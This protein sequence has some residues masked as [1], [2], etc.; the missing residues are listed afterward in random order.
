[1]CLNFVWGRGEVGKVFLSLCCRQISSV[2]NTAIAELW[3]SCSLLQRSLTSSS[4]GQIIQRSLQGA[5]TIYGLDHCFLGLKE[6][7]RS[8]RSNKWVCPID[9]QFRVVVLWESDVF[10]RSDFYQDEWAMFG[11][12]LIMPLVAFILGVFHIL[13]VSSIIN[14]LSILVSKNSLKCVCSQFWIGR[15]A[16]TGQHDRKSW[17]L[18]YILSDF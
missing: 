14:C 4:R 7:L 5:G 8:T 1:M 10:W 15:A 6:V 16:Y 18:L 9:M 12:S 13:L 17:V 2:K 11:F 3:T